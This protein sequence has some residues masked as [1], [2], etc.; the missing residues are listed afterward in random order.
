MDS[1]VGRHAF[2]AEALKKLD[3]ASN[4]AETTFL[5]VAV[6]VSHE[7]E[8]LGYTVAISG[9]AINGDPGFHKEYR[10]RACLFL[11][12]KPERLSQGA[13]TQANTAMPKGEG[14]SIPPLIFG[15]S[16]GRVYSPRVP[17]V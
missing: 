13:E 10:V 2:F 12:L 4:D 6:E 3:E 5:N 17:G 16:V 8:D 9:L 15:R 1:V 14:S 7:M 11:L